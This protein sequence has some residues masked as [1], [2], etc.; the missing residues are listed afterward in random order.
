MPEGPQVTQVIEQLI[1]D[2]NK[3]IFGTSFGYQ[4]YMLAEAQK[5]PDVKFE[6][7]TGTKKD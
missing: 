6:Q 7:A 5:H 1:Q 3:I 2:G 4:D